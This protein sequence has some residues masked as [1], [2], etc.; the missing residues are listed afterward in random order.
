MKYF[1]VYLE[2]GHIIPMQ[3]NDD[4]IKADEILKEIH[5]KDEVVLVNSLGATAAILSFK[6]IA[7]VESGH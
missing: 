3:H 6:I 7:V 4:N 2:G 1:D 5:S